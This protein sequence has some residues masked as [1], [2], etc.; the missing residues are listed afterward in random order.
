[1]TWFKVDDSFHSHPKVLATDPA[2]LGLWVVAGAWCSSN[3]TDGFVPDYALPRLL[4]DG[5]ELA[6]KLVTSGLWTRTKG[7]YRYHDWLDYNPSADTVRTEREAAKKRMRDLREKRGANREDTGQSAN[8]SGEQ[9]AN[10]RE[11]FGRRSQ[12]RPD[13]NTSTSS[14]EEVPTP[15]R[16]DVLKVCNHL[17]DRV[18]ANGSK[19]PKVTKEWLDEARR[20]LDL[21]KR[22]VEQVMTAID[23]CQGDSFWR[24]NVMSMPTLRKQF[25]RLRESALH[26][27]RTRK[28]AA[29]AR[30]V[31]ADTRSGDIDW[32]DPKILEF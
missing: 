17:A 31:G 7:G 3:L 13:P 14:K 18:A 5:A 6:K 9:G 20:L 28:A 10:V 25:D 21:D 2:A 30:L 15:P 1:M 23:W 29:P 4:P 26:E 19:K 8:R 24:G 32:S 11:K 22:T 16:L 12:P 27:Q